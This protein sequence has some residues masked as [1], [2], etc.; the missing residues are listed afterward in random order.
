MHPNTPVA[1]VWRSP[2]S[3]LT[4]QWDPGTG[5]PP[6]PRS[7]LVTQQMDEARERRQVEA[8]RVLRGWWGDA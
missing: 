3:E 7:V 2:V 8:A 6:D 1:W 5:V 4:V